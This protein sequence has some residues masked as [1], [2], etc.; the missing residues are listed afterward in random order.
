[1]GV[2]SPEPR[3]SIPIQTR[4][5]LRLVDLVGDGDLAFA[6]TGAGDSEFAAMTPLPLMFKLAPVAVRS[7][8][9]LTA[10]TAYCHLTLS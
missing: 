6:S 1:M 8:P 9:P 5:I 10:M 7:P 4:E 2:A 3:P